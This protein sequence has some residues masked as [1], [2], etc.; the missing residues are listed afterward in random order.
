MGAAVLE[1]LARRAARADVRLLPGR[2]TG[3]SAATSASPG[4]LTGDDVAAA[5]AGQPEDDRYLLPDVVLSRG[6]FLDGTTVGASAACRSRSSPTDGAA[7][8]DAL[9]RPAPI[10]FGRGLMTGEL[11]VVAVVGRPNVGKSTLVNR[12]VGR[13]AAIV[14]ERPGVTRDR[15]E[16]VGGVDRPHVSRSSTP[17]AGSP[18][19]K[20]ASPA[21]SR[22]S[23]PR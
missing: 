21:R 12:I 15:R 6:R 5:L 2:R 8:V 10:P 20:P 18:K 14:E 13:R 3:S 16:L 4:L 7:L 22:R 19:A 1:P 23:R 17:A 11:P 9:R